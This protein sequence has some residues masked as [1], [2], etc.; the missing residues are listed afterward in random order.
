MA[1][2]LPAGL[3][4][5]PA[6][7]HGRLPRGG[8]AC[9][10]SRHRSPTAGVDARV[11]ARTVGEAAQRVGR[12]SLV[13]PVAPV[14]R[15][16]RSRAAG[17]PARQ[18]GLRPFERARCRRLA[19][20][21]PRSDRAAARTWGPAPAWSRRCGGSG[22]QPTWLVTGSSGSA[23]RRAADA[24]RSR[25][26]AQ[27][28][29]RRG[30]G[31][32]AAVPLPSPRGAA[33]RS[34]IA[35]VPAAHG[36]LAGAGAAGRQ[37]LPGSFAV[38]AFVYSNPIVLAGAGAGVVDRRA[39]PQARARAGRVGALGAEPRRL[40]RDRQRPRRAARA[41]R[42]SST[43]S[44]CRSSG[45]ID[46]SA[47]ALAE[48]GVLAL[49]ILVVLMAFAV[50]A[51]CVD[52][53]RVLRLLRP[54]ARR[55]ALTATLIARLVPLAA[56][57]HA[58]LGEAAA[59]ARPGRGACGPCCA[60][61]PARRGLAR[62]RGGRCRDAGAARATRAGAPGSA[63]GAPSGAVRGPLP[64]SR[65][66][67]R[68]DRRR[69]AIAGVGALRL[70]SDRRASTS[71]RPRSPLPL[72]CP[73]S[74]P[75]PFAA[76]RRGWSA[77]WLS[78]WS[79]IGRLALPLP[80]APRAT[81]SS[82]S[83]SRSSPGELVVLA[84]RSGS[85]KTT[86]LRA[87]CG[88]VPHYHGGDV[89]GEA[90]RRRASTFASTGR[91]SSAAPSASSARTPRRR[92]C[93]TTVRAE[94]ELPLEIR[95]EPPAARARA[96]EEVA[97]ALGDAAA[98]RPA[99]S[100]PSPAASCSGSRSPPRS[101][102]RPRLVLLDE[103]TSQLDP[104]AG[105]EL[106]RAAAPAERGVGDGGACSPSI[107]SSAAWRPPTACSPWPAARIAFD[108]TPA[109][110]PATGRSGTTPALATPARALFALAG[111]G[112]AAGRRSRQARA[113]AA[114]AAVS[115]ARATDRRRPVA[116]S[117]G[118]LPGR[119][120][121]TGRRSSCADAVG[122]AR[123]RRRAARRPARA[124]TSRSQP[125]ERV[126]LM[127]RNGAGKSHAPA[128]R[129]RTARAGARDGL[130]ARRAARCCRR[131]RA[132]SWSASASRDELPG[133]PGGAALEAVGLDWAERRAT[134]ATC[135]AASA[136]GWRWRS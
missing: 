6:P 112:A 98:A 11:E 85:G 75:L 80:G 123:R 27:P 19:S 127:G 29:R 51:A 119:Q 128:R 116:P 57:D 31:A 66:R 23:V 33:V 117:A 87:C 122:R 61:A 136:S 30:D 53:D 83:T 68:R 130:G 1:R 95:G 88:L 60:G 65:Y 36:P 32:R 4:P 64:G 16:R 118:R 79:A 72:A 62:P 121:R 22:D 109:G 41:T 52:P 8:R 90:A 126:A 14:R 129:G 40:H 9:D 39:L 46:V 59:A 63:R 106:D 76:A 45:H 110:L 47:E 125:G 43:G 48:G 101:S 54:L 70:L 56:A 5:S 35:Y 77:A 73:C 37:R 28:L 134:R 133:E 69:R 93:S 131:A 86:L 114:R 34:P 67:D 91:P 108:G 89:R 50:H 25:L 84:G 2:A 78:R 13:G 94:L 49:R 92:S 105:D 132:T 38:V 3:A 42:S 96:V 12:G 7:G 15:T 104:V 82:T 74:P 100:T 71:A 115:T 58:R 135:R 55:S 102:A 24:R 10:A 113:H 120:R 44:G 21:R 111:L 99:P 103:P 18:R 107:G 20:D 124:S 17:V 26:A 81:R 97:L